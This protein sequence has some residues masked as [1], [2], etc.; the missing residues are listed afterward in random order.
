MEDFFEKIVELNKSGEPAAFAVVI[1]TE[2]STPRRV[3]AKMIIMKD[4]KTKRSL[5]E[6]SRPCRI[7][8]RG[9]DS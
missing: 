2:G 7:G 3:G 1:K 8:Y 5:F 4:G 9:G 6:T